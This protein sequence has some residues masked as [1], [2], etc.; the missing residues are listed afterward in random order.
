MRFGLWPII[1]AKYAFDDV[2]QF[3]RKVD[4]SRA[5]AI[6]AGRVIVF[7]Q[8]DAKR[9]VHRRNRAREN[10]G[11]PGRTFFFHCEFMFV[12]KCFDASNALRVGPVALLEFLTA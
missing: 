6:P 2:V 11:A 9:L 12:G 4:H 3:R 5:P 10:H 1:Q 8:L 7:L